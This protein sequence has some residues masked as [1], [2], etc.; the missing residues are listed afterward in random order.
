MD[1]R[2]RFAGVAV[3]V[4]W[5]AASLALP[6]VAPF[7]P[8]FSHTVYSGWDAFW[9]GWQ[10]LGMA[11]PGEVDWWVFGG[12]WLANP[13]VWASAVATLANHRRLGTWTAGAA[14]ALTVP[15]LARL[16]TAVAAHPGFWFWTGSAALLGV[17]SC[18]RAPAA[19]Q[20]H[21]PETDTP[22]EPATAPPP[23]D[24]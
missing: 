16:G 19:A 24:G 5:Y 7:N 18:M 13:L 22:A 10:A 2:V 6:A 9:A 11:E 15:V 17:L 12:A 21:E 23:A 14:F 3:A 8:E 20:D 4:G 1:S